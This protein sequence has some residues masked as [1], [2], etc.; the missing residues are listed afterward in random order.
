MQPHQDVSE[1]NTFWATGMRLGD[2]QVT[3]VSGGRDSPSFLSLLCVGLSCSSTQACQ[4]CMSSFDVYIG[5]HIHISLLM[6][7]FSLLAEIDEIFF[8]YQFAGHPVSRGRFDTPREI[9]N[10]LGYISCMIRGVF[11]KLC[12]GRLAVLGDSSTSFACHSNQV[13]CLRSSGESWL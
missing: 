1:D 4:S 5:I 12:Q 6:W 2:D 7:M 11:C 3:V 9:G 8:L 13:C 10:Q